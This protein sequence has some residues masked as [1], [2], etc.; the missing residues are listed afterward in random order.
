[1]K[2][3]VNI[4][5]SGNVATHLAM[6]L[7]SNGYSIHA[8]VSRSKSNAQALATQVG[9]TPT[10][11]IR[12]LPQADITIIAVSDNSIA[13]VAQALAAKGERGVVVHTSGATAMSALA[14]LPRHGVL[15]P[16]MTFS[17]ADCIDMRQCPFLIEASDGPTLTIVKNLAESI[18]GVATECDS[19]GRL[20]LH[21][22]AVFASN[23]TNHMLLKA[24]QI[25]S[26]AGLPLSLLK[27]LTLQTVGKAFSMGPFDA[28]TGPARRNDTAAI[29]RH[30]SLLPFND[31]SKKIY[32][33]VTKSIMATY[34]VDK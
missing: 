8:V 30:E 26:G 29:E 4:I 33:A 13:S 23:F 2:P 10:A 14:P 20:R 3:T 18:G 17:K 11:S 19:N 9:A 28:Q 24:E 15:Y 34:G 16:C 22:A 1:M 25:L 7:K 31:P 5:G 12:Q 32:E 27:P 6:A 21:L